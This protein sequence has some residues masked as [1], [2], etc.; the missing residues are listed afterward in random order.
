MGGGGRGGRSRTQRKHFRQSRENVWKRSKSDPDPSSTENNPSWTPF[1]TENAAFDF[2]YK[3]QGIVEPQQWEQFVAVLRTPLPATFRINSSSQFSDDIR[4]QLENDFVHSLRDEVGEGGETEAIRPLLWYPGN[5]AWHSNFS[6][7]QLRKNQTLERF[8]EFLKLEN[9]IGNITRQEAVSMVPPLFL[10]VHSDHFVLDMCAAP[11]SKTFQLLEIIHQS[12]KS[13]SLPD[14]MVTANDLDVQRC[15]LLIHQTKRM[16][17]ANL[18]VTNHEAQ[19]FPGCRLNRNYEKI[20]LD[21]NIGQLLFDRVLC[22]VPCSG[23][24]TLRKAPDLWRKWNTGMGHGLHSLQVLIAMRGISLLKIGGRMVYSTCSMNPIE[25]E[26]V[27]AEVLRRCGGSIELVDV[28][29]ELP[30]L[31]RRPGLKK[32]KVYDK[33]SWFVSY[34]GVPKFRRSVILSSMFPSGR[35]HRDV[36]DSSCNVNVEVGTNGINENVGDI[37]ED[38]GDGVQP[39]LNP[40]MS[41]SV[42]EVSDFPL[43]HCMRIVPHDQNTGAFFI[44]VL[45]KVSPLPV[46]PEK[47]KVKIH[48]QYVDPASQSL[49]DAQVQQITSPENAHEEDFKAVSEE[50]ADDNEPNTQDMEDDPVACEEQKTKE[51]LEP[52]NV[53]NTMKRVP[54]KR[55]LQI[56]G[57]WRGVDPVVFFKDE[58]IINSIRDFYGIDE[59][60]PFNGH[61]VTRNSDANH[62]KR[63]YYISKSVKDVLELN[64]KVGQQLKITSIGLKMFERQTA[65]E[66]SSAPCAFRIS[67]EGLPLILPYITKQILH[68]SPADFKHLLMN[69]EVKFEDFTDAKFGEKAANLLPG[70]CVVILSLGNTTA[71]ESLQV[72]ESTIAIG[73]W[74]GRARLSVMVTAMDCQELLERLLIRFDNVNGS[75]GHV[76]KS[77][78]DEEEIRPVQD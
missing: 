14:G 73:C 60:F 29:S 42:E 5:F 2:Y 50:N 1:A 27:V 19:N 4:S 68:A 21:H 57:K 48:E 26:A 24:G 70:C 20:E 53:Q 28:S 47:P 11:G 62:V 78:N 59:R 39:V 58:I 13:G 10:D 65:R 7:M 75:S 77:S 23:D 34:N 44:A 22:D 74:K 38:A 43:E 69:K 30:Q 17:T 8:H 67:S 71:V 64:F 31:I 55:K 52:D 63:I 18:I 66:G 40:V 37:N 25:N 15:N 54:G 51:N 45:Q 49:N 16:C 9:E 33:G 61:L 46:I 72:D 76:H 36:V 12:S 32:W 3:E 6:R 35:G 56:Q 41:E